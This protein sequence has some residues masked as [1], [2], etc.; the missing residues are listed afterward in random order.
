MVDNTRRLGADERA[1]GTGSVFARG[2]KFV[3]VLP[4]HLRPPHQKTFDT[5][6]EAHEWL[7]AAL[8]GLAPH[9]VYLPKELGEEAA[10]K[11]SENNTT[12]SKLVEPDATRSLERYLNKD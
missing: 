3:G 4:P 11:A 5:P 10:A 8:A 2:T 12:V 1:K 9:I 7:D 6:K